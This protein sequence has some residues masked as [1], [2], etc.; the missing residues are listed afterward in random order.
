MQL[1]YQ[2]LLC[3]ASA[4]A[5]LASVGVASAQETNAP[6]AA[7]A[8][9]PTVVTDDIVVT[10]YRQSLETAQAIKKN[11]DQIVD[12]IVA[13]D[14]G[15]L[16]DST[17]AETLARVTGV[18]VER[19]TGEAAAIRVRGLPDLTTT[20]NGR[21]LFTAEGRSV[22]L[23]DFPSG[24]ISRFDVYKT[25]AANLIEPGIAGEIDV[26][27]R[28]PFDFKDF[29]I[30][31]GITGLH[32]Q[33]SQRFGIDA[34]LLV[35]KRWTSGIGEIGVLLEGSYTDNKFTDDHRTNNNAIQTRPANAATFP[36]AQYPALLTIQPDVSNRFRPSVGAAVQWRPSSD[37]EIYSDFLFQGF[38]GRGFGYGLQIQAGTGAT[39]SNVTYCDGSTTQICKMTATGGNATSAYQAGQFSQTDTYQAGT[40][41]I[42]TPGSAR[43]SGDFAF[44]DSV[45]TSTNF[46]TAQTTLTTGTRVFDFDNAEAGGG[47]ARVVDIDLTNPAN[48]RYSGFSQANSRNHGRSYQAKLDADVPVELALFD[49]L[50][51][52][53]RFND[54]AAD[55]E[56][57]STDPAT[58]TSLLSGTIT[59][60]TPGSLLTAAPLELVP[61]DPSYKND[62]TDHPRTWVTP[63][64]ESVIHYA[65]YIRAMASNALLRTT[66]MPARTRNYDSAEKSYAAYLQT[67]YAFD[68]GGMKVDGQLGLRAVRTETEINGLQTTVRSGVRTIVPIS[69]SKTYD[70][71]L[72]NISAR[73]RFSPELQ[74]RLAF[75]KTRTRPSFGQLNPT[76]TINPQAGCTGTGCVASASGGNPD[77]EPIKSTNYDASLEYYFS[78]SG[79]ASVQVFQRDIVGFINNRTLSYQDPD[80][81]T[82]NV[83][84]PANGEQGRIRGV[85]AGFRTFLNFA[86]LPD[87][88]RNFGV[89]ANYTYLDHWSVLSQAVQATLPGRQPITNVSKHLANAQIFYETKD[90]SLRASYNYRS[91]FRFYSQVDAAV[92]TLP[93]FERG[94]GVLDLSAGINPTSNLSLTFNAANILSNPARNFR[95]FNRAG[96]IYPWQVRYLETVYRLGARFRF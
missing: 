80:L 11:S 74:A 61:V 55:S 92:G 1:H 47:T 81:G 66:G 49:K 41:F 35:S 38:R 24:T 94:R 19:G 27:S 6:A 73:I 89:L 20:Y 40:G 3:G 22:A 21:E 25:G 16:P 70:D 72:P 9:D 8:E 53:V 84:Q 90:L 29:R 34:N 39:L 77:L 26:R 63:T 96:A 12:S 30:A 17:G 15:K 83:N 45:F 58:N 57:L 52:G 79:S 88:M 50:Q 28:K 18:S 75:T 2:G 86:G 10:G 64:R 46:Q 93:T 13:E 51:F 4:L 59:A 56:A 48:W 71:Y 36:G 60:G 85:E 42:W 54:R 62:P 82:V 43:I 91:S 44:T 5:M 32:W 7:P 95:Q 69:R 87:W 14:I 31:G 68:V 23:Q 67:H 33:N 76:I 65:D 78:R 37:L